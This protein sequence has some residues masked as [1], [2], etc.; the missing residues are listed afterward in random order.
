MNGSKCSE[1]INFFI[2][3]KKGLTIPI[4]LLT[5]YAEENFVPNNHVI[6]VLSKPIKKEKLEKIIRKLNIDKTM[7]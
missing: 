2:S 6:E 1:L 5:G 3:Y 7:K 4:Y